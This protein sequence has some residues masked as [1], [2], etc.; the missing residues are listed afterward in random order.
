MCE[1]LRANSSLL[2]IVSNH[3]RFENNFKYYIFEETERA[4]FYGKLKLLNSQTFFFYFTEHV[5]LYIAL[6]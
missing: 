4:P 6:Y 2:I 5:Y 3:F 1:Y